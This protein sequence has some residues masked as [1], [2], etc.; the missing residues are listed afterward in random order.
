MCTAD[1]WVVPPTTNVPFARLAVT[2]AVVP[3]VLVKLIV[4][5]ACEPAESTPV[6]VTLTKSSWAVQ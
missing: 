2:V 6:T 1:A 4:R 3:K 5:L